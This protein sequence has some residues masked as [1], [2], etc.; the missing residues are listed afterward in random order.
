MTE[1][2]Q[3][4]LLGGN[5]M[6]IGASGTGKTHCLSTLVEAGLELACIFTEAGGHETLLKA[7][8]EKGLP[9]DKV[10]WKYVMPAVPDINDMIKSAEMINLMSFKDLTGIKSGINKSSYKQWIDLLLSLKEFVD[11]R[12]GEDLGSPFDWGP[13]RAFV[14]DGLSGMNLMSMDLTVGSKP[15]KAEGEWGVAMDNEERLIQK[16]CNDT[17]CFFVLIAHLERR[18]NPVTGVLTIQADAL[19]KAL[20]P[21]LPRWFSEVALVYREGNKFFW[22]TADVDVDLR[23]RFLPIETKLQPSF[24]QVVEDWQELMRI[25][26]GEDKK[27]AAE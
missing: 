6:L 19:G 21:K 14:I 1:P 27:E 23:T 2:T 7:L 10:Y 9:N 22:S 20:A 4:P 15:V 11:D 12:T 13:E 17:K 18:A 8:E 26:K 16:L 5:V 25:A 24:I 3:S